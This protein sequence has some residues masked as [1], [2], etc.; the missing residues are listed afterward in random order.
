MNDANENDEDNDIHIT[1]NRITYC[2]KWNERYDNPCN[3]YQTE[4]EDHN[5]Q[6]EQLRES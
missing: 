5:R 6:T 1:A 2:Q 4:K 3:W